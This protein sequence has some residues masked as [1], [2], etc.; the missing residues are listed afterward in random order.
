MMVNEKIRQ[1]LEDHGISSAFI[2]EKSGLSPA[3]IYKALRGER[4]LTAE[5]LGKIA[6]ALNVDANIFLN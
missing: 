3:A 4:K 1:Y 6:M 2:I 5:E